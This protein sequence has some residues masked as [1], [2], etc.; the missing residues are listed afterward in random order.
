VCHSPAVDSRGSAG[1]PGAKIRITP[2]VIAAGA[3][4]LLRFD[5]DFESFEAGAERIFYEMISALASEKL[6]ERS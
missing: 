4:E 5:K 2:A 1:A 3:A 6:I